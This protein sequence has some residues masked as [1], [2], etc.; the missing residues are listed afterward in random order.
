MKEGKNIETTMDHDQKQND[1]IIENQTVNTETPTATTKTDIDNEGR[2]KDEKDFGMKTENETDSKP[3]SAVDNSTKENKN[4]QRILDLPFKG[5][6]TTNIEKFLGSALK[7]K[8]LEQ[9]ASMK[10]PKLNSSGSLKSCSPNDRIKR[11]LTGQIGNSSFPQD[12]SI[13]RNNSSMNS[14]ANVGEE[15]SNEI[16]GEMPPIIKAG[17]EN[18]CGNYDN[19]NFSANGD[20]STS[21]SVPYRKENEALSPYDDIDQYSNIL[22]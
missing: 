6:F 13:N 19:N 7:G 3:I 8:S 15:K 9:L 5:P 12:Q 18:N 11:L 21:N 20:I 17:S 1:D 4:V 2:S 14:E 10:L 16:D 22:K